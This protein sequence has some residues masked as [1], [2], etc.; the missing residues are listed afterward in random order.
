VLELRDPVVHAVDR[1]V[2][3]ELSV[4]PRARLGEAVGLYVLGLGQLEVEQVGL[5]RLRADLGLDVLGLER[6]EVG[7]VYD[8]VSFWVMV[9]RASAD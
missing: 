3:V 8:G 1:A 9:S 2:D 5:Q 6:P 4:V 7:Q